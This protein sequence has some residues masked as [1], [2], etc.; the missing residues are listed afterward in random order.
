MGNQIPDY[1]LDNVAHQDI[2][3]RK[4]ITDT[5]SIIKQVDPQ[6]VIYTLDTRSFRK[7]VSEDYKASRTK[8]DIFYKVLD[9]IKKLLRHKQLNAITIEGLEADDLMQ[10]FADKYDKEP[11]IIIS[12]DEDIRQL[13][14]NTCWVVNV[15]GKDKRIYSLTPTVPFEIKGATVHIVDPELIAA[16]KVL[17]GCSG[18]EVA[19]LAPKGFRTTKI[20]SIADEVF[21]Q[22]HT[23]PEDVIVLFWKAINKYFSVTMEQVERQ[24]RLVYLHRYFLPTSLVDEFDNLTIKENRML[25]FTFNSI[26]DNTRYFDVNYSKK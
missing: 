6:H 15:Q 19:G 8:S 23:C 5:C 14:S 17:K 22:P 2:L 10:L 11:L 18:D 13:V 1:N 9:D 21:A 3:V 24:L 26:L 16:T 20:K 12:A 25:D 7:D 4:F